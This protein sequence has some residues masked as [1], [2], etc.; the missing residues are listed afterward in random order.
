MSNWWVRRVFLIAQFAA[1][2]IFLSSPL[3]STDIMHFLE[4][5]LIRLR[6]HVRK[7]RLGQYQIICRPGRG[8]VLVYFILSL[9]E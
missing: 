3:S 9:L 6:K 2:L 8:R 5:H 1:I 4:A 7:E